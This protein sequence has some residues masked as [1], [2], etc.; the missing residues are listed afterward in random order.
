MTCFHPSR[1]CI[2]PARMRS[3]SILSGISSTWFSDAQLERRPQTRQR[4]STGL[5]HPGT[6]HPGGVAVLPIC[7]T[8]TCHKTGTLGAIKMNP[9]LQKTRERL[10]ALGFSIPEFGVDGD[11]GKEA[12]DPVK[13]DLPVCNSY[14]FKVISGSGTS[15]DKSMN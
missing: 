13:A 10:L 15:S 8:T 11:Y 1:R 5:G 2:C 3:V 7:T 9:P 14:G 12:D 4:T 6:R